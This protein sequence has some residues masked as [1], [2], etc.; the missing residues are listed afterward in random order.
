[1]SVSFPPELSAPATRALT[2][3]GITSA[4]Q[5]ATWTETDVLA[6]HGIGP[7]S[8]PPLRAAL[9]AEGLTFADGAATA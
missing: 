9:A 7:S 5:L 3:A 6:L 2:N 1:M 8:L 4:T